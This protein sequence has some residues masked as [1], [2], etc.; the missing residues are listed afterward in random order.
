ME[1]DEVL[2]N[3]DGRS[4]IKFNE[5]YSGDETLKEESQIQQLVLTALAQLGRILNETD[6]ENMRMT[7]DVLKDLI[8]NFDKFKEQ[9]MKRA[10]LIRIRAALEK[11]LNEQFSQ[12][13]S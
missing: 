10:I 8:D 13:L 11:E 1:D 12:I 9:E 4:L 2:K 5:P 3:G 6:L 7:V